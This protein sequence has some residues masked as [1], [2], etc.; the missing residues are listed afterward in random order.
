M[1]LEALER[2][3]A[4]TSELNPVSA[5]SEPKTTGK[6][7]GS[8]VA[9]PRTVELKKGGTQSSKSALGISMGHER[10]D[11]TGT[12]D[13]GFDTDPDSPRGPVRPASPMPAHAHGR[14][15]FSAKPL[16]SSSR[17]LKRP[18]LLP[19][20]PTR[21][22]AV[23]GEPD[24]TTR[25]ARSPTLTREEKERLTAERGRVYAAANL[26]TNGDFFTKFNRKNSRKSRKFLWFV[27]QDPVTPLLFWK[28]KGKERKHINLAQAQ[29][30]QRG[31]G[32]RPLQGRAARTADPERCFSI[33]MKK[34]GLTLDLMAEK[35]QVRDA[36][37]EA[38]EVII[39]SAQEKKRA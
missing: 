20:K 29:R 6:D 37:A 21:P 26:L 11:S 14:P 7:T 8:D 4:V 38:L 9:A 1:D 34:K 36:W 24:I 30:V 2:Q 18:T 23:T 35:P 19:L 10:G 22:V 32:T 31:K 12:D 13:P 25:V 3:V 16:G 39:E 15:L 5:P 27:Q 17:A 28:S 33:I